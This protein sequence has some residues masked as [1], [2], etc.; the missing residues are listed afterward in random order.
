[1]L[2]TPLISLLILLL[3]LAGSIGLV[4]AMVWVLVLKSS[5]K[6]TPLKGHLLR[7]PGYSLNKRL[8]ELN[9]KINGWVVALPITA[10]GIAYIYANSGSSTSS[11]GNALVTYIFLALIYCGVVGTAI[12]KLW[13]H[14]RYRRDLR[15][16]LDCEMS[17]GQE[18]NH[19][20]RDGYY[21]YHDFPAEYGNID[22]VVIGQNGVFA[23][24]TKGRAKAKHGEDPVN[25]TVVYDGKTLKFPNWTGDEYV[26]QARRQAEW[27]SKWLTGE[28][29]ERV[30]ARAVLVLPG[31]FVHRQGRSDV[32]VLGGEGFHFLLKQPPSQALEPQ[33]I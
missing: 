14:F 17:V 12:F 23:V 20:M 33:L 9:E 28:I 31:W 8:E 13:Q 18:L 21:V 1:M 11:G 24:E 27:L 22:H 32:M 4:W 3:A 2:S 15:L 5:H 7:P 26:Q 29:A 10:I 6:R 19:L 30:T 16:G 25:A